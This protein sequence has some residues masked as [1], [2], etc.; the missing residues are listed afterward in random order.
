MTSGLQPFIWHLKRTHIS[1][2]T[3]FVFCLFFSFSMT[4]NWVTT[5]TDLS[6]YAY[7]VILE[8]RILGLWKLCHSPKLRHSMI[9]FSIFVHN[10]NIIINLTH[11]FYVTFSF[12][13]ESVWL[14]IQ[15]LKMLHSVFPLFFTITTEVHIFFVH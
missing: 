1:F 4:N 3:R 9:Y 2:V 5:V 10:M 14:N 13:Y 12:D 8:V 6:F 11:L 7:V 15:Y